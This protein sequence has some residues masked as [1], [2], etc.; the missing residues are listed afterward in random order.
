MHV[1]GKTAEGRGAL[2][3]LRACPT[4]FAVSDVGIGAVA[5][6]PATVVEWLTCGAEIAFAFRLISELRIPGHVNTDSG[7]M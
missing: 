7:A 3:P 2:R 4:T 1:D 5:I 6:T